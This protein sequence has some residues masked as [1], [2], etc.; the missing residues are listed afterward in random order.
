MV[1][2]IIQL[3]WGL[4]SRYGLSLALPLALYHFAD[5][6]SFISSLLPGKRGRVP[7]WTPNI[8]AL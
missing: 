5:N 2:L 4:G 6:L 3:N 1:F 8:P 7:I